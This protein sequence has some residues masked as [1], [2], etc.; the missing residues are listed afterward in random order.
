MADCHSAGSGRCRNTMKR[1]NRSRRESADAN[2]SSGLR[3]APAR[4]R[5][6]Y[7]WQVAEEVEEE[8]VAARPEPPRLPRAQPRTRRRCR[9]RMP[10]SSASWG[11]RNGSMPTTGRTPTPAPR[12]SSIRSIGNS[13]TA[14]SSSSCTSVTSWTTATAAASTT[15]R[16]WAA[17]PTPWRTG[18][19]REYEGT[20]RA[21]P[22]QRRD[23]YLSAARQ[24]RRRASHRSS[25]CW[26]ISPDPAW[27]IAQ[28]LSGACTGRQQSGRR[29]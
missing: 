26:R 2:S 25:I 23:R 1:M 11:T 12:T 29:R 8:T 6:R 21:D 19:W 22:L 17:E 14:A 7:R 28:C 13:S 18:G 9:R 3:P 27:R 10:G 24:S 20:V 16:R 15:C 5:H 4:L